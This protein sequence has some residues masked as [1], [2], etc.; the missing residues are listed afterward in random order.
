MDKRGFLRLADTAM[1]IIFIVIIG[2]A[3]AIGGSIF[4]GNLIDVRLEESVILSDKLVKA[5][6]DNGQVN[7]DVFESDF[8]ILKEAGI[9]SEIKKGAYFFRLE[10]FGEKSRVFID[11]QRDFE[12]ECELEGGDFPRC[13]SKDFFID[14]YEI[15]ILTASRQA[16]GEI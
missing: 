8:N 2:G 10:I 12:V 13:F 15:K 6:V 14:D 1:F 9:N 11:G 3:V 5:V 7:E 4:Y 16:G